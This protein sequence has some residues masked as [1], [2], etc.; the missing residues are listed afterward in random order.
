[1]LHNMALNNMQN[2]LTKINGKHASAI[3]QKF[4]IVCQLHLQP[5]PNQNLAVGWYKGLGHETVQ[6]ATV[7]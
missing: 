2:A 6:G 5:L 1:M 3:G 4:G 7:N